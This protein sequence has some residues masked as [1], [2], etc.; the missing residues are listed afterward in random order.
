MSNRNKFQG[1]ANRP[2]VTENDRIRTRTGV[3]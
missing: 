2:P 1:D 3:Y